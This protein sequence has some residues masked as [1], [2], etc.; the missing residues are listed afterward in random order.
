VWWVPNKHGNDRA[1]S[2]GCGERPN[3]RTRLQCIEWRGYSSLRFVFSSK[4]VLKKV[5]HVPIHP[6]SVNLTEPYTSN[7]A[8]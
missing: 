8:T 4:E 1:D 2:G 6:F 3:A 7:P 5:D